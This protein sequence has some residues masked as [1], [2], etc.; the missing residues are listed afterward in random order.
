MGAQK[1]RLIETVLLSTYNISFCWEI[2]KIIFSCA[3]LSGACLMSSL[4][5]LEAKGTFT[6]LHVLVYMQFPRHILWN[7]NSFKFFVD[8]HVSVYGLWSNNWIW[9]ALSFYALSGYCISLSERTFP[10]FSP[11]PTASVGHLVESGSHRL[12]VSLCIP[13]NHMR[14]ILN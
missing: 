10:I 13:H 1:N 8:L 4:F 9:Q 12:I 11:N 7:L 5:I 2:R 14:I 3:L 6:F